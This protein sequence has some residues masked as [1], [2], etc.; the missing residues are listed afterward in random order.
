MSRDVFTLTISRGVVSVV[1][2]RGGVN[3]M[4]TVGDDKKLVSVGVA[5]EVTGHRPATIRSWCR[6]H[7]LPAYK[8]GKSIRISLTDLRRFI[9][10]SRI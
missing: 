1:Y 8:I 6:E 4:E 5:A 2:G 3:V 9:E 10:E 7:K